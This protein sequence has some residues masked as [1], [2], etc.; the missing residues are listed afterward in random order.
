[1]SRHWHHLKFD[2]FT[3]TWIF[4][5]GLGNFEIISMTSKEQKLPPGTHPAKE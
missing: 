5:H 2:H 1:M 3:F 4:L